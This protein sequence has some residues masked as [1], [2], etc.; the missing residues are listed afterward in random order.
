MGFHFKEKIGKSGKGHSIVYWFRLFLLLLLFFILLI[1]FLF[2][3][4]MKSA[5]ICQ[6]VD[7]LNTIFKIYASEMDASFNSL[8]NYL[9]ATLSESPAM[10]RIET[11]GTET[12]TAFARLDIAKALSNIASWDKRVES[13]IFYS[14]KSPDKVLIENGLEPEFQNRESMQQQL[15]DWIDGEIKKRTI[16][17][18]GYMIARCASKDYILRFYKI[19]NSYVGMGIAL[20]SILSSLQASME[21]RDS[22]LF[23]AGNDGT[24]LE[25][26]GDMPGQIDIS[27]NGTAADVSGTQMLQI[28]VMSQN[29]DFYVGQML[30]ASEIFVGIN[31]VRTMLVVMVVIVLAVVELF[32]YLICRFINYPAEQLVFGMKRTGEGQWNEPLQ[33]TGCVREFRTLIS[34]FNEM[35]HEIK[36]LKIKNYEAQLQNQ[37]VYLQYLQLQINP[38][39]YLNALNIVYSLAEIGDFK[40]IQRMILALVKYLRY[41]FQDVNTLVTVTQELEHVRSYIDISQIRFSDAID[42]E[43]RPDADVIEALIPPF[44]IQSFVENSI[45]YA[46][47]NRKKG[48]LFIQ[49][50]QEAENDG[51]YLMIEIRDNGNGYSDEVIRAINSGHVLED[52][53]GGRVGIRNVMERLALIYGDKAE[54]ALS[55]DGGAVT[56]I[57]LPLIL[58]EM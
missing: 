36:N 41:H 3:R 26:T 29:G 22:L 21:D 25:A 58:K 28:N 33:V 11:G 45:K 7:D 35:I 40:T 50:W 49:A 8:Q 20:E 32:V 9:Y 55:N 38:H 27:E 10:T 24:V 47:K 43:E 44:I 16:R 56:H 15:K 48:R 37:K 14:P 13:L 53:H 1:G 42:Y 52:S 17:R 23:I 51:E 31:H 39:F 46:L 34:T 2:E 19:H 54:V 57:R 18:S 6:K 5:L 4:S 30:A 12:E